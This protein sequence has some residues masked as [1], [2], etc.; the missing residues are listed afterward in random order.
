[1][2]TQPNVDVAAHPLSSTSLPRSL[3]FLE[4]WG[5]GLTGHLTWLST[6]PVIH[7]AL[8][9]QAILVWV[10]GV[11]IG[12]L[13]NLQVKR[14]GEHWPEVAGGTPNYTTWLLNN[15]SGLGRYAALG[16]FFSWVGFLP[17]N[18]IVLTDLIRGNLEPLGIPCPQLPLKIGFTVIAFVVAFSG[19]RALGILHLFFILPAFGFLFVFC[20]Q[21]LGWLALSPASP[22]FFPLSWGSSLSVV[23]WLKWLFFVVF[24]TYSCESAS[25]FVADSERP[26]E[27]LRF[28]R[29]AAWLIALVYLGGSWVLMRLA[30][31]PGLASDPFL[32]LLAAANS[33]WGDSASFFVTFLVVS[34]SLLG[35]ATAVANTPRILYQLALDGHI[36]PVFAV[37]S[38]RG[39]LGPSLVF[40]LLLSLVCLAWGDVARIVIVTGVGWLSCFMALHLGLWLR[41]GRPEVLWPRLSLGFLLLEVM[42]FVVGGIAWGW[43][44]W[45]IGLL[46]PIGILGV[47]AAIR[48]IAFPPF[49]PAWW[50]EH[51]RRPARPI[52]DFV[53]FQVVVLIV[54]VCCSAAVSWVLRDKLETLSNSAGNDLLVVLLLTI[55]FVAIAIACWTSL[56]QVAAIAEAREYTENLFITALD[57]VP[58]T[59]LVLNEN[60]IIRQA[61]PAAEQLFE[62]NTLELIG[63]HLHEFFSELTDEPVNWP[64]W[65][66][67][68]LAKQDQSFRIIET[69]ISKRLNRKL[70]EYIVILRDITERKQSEQTLQQS[71]GRLRKQATQLEQTLQ[72]L[73]STQAQLIQ[74]EKMSSL[75]QLVAGVAHEINNPINFIYGNL[76]HVNNYTQDLLA[77]ISLYQECYLHPEP[78]IQDRIEEVELSFLI[79]D[80]PKTLTSMKVGADRIR[81]IVLTLR[82]FSRLD[83]SQM[84]PVNIHE[85]I[86][87]TLLILQNR[88]KAK[89]DYPGIEIIKEY[90]TL[91]E[92]ECYAG[93]L[94][95]VFMN[96][97]G[98]AIDALHKHDKYYSLEEIK[99][100]R[101]T[102]TIHTQVIDNHWVRISI[103]DNGPGMSESIKARLFDPFFTTKAVGEGT[104]LGLSISYQIVVDKHGGKLQ[105]LSQPGQGA[106][107]RIEIPLKQS[108]KLVSSKGKTAE[109]QE[110]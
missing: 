105:C 17:I 22:G 89:P 103:K 4:T 84:K 99:S 47:D 14:L 60:G 23:E 76:T 35:S 72:D 13:L 65:S 28:L 79:E 25:A 86:D 110:S 15:Y 31:Q 40:T 5:F 75:G 92:V 21:G 43:Q 59:V 78:K 80:L 10:P 107:F 46:C 30:T 34:G 48:H 7:A 44:D 77:L 63:N 109:G 26:S 83:E 88:L 101:S 108:R 66:E 106:E 94:N 96:I 18:A 69:T 39:V 24:S 55:A 9:P 56:P 3:S 1:M 82:N 20:L 27:T 87:S 85:G 73:Q 81:Q 90:G 8:G 61:N 42:V 29:L 49:Q 37:V 57:T 53:A 16:Y 95:Q 50:I 38:R 32:N 98:N 12:M 33:F 70:Q 41:R 11:I 36:S 68:I 6:A 104:G 54:L 71:E 58:D 100:N 19:T 74:T 51:D 102:I 52:K 2:P 91:P 45:I 97:L 64:N 62:I 93:Q 67:Q